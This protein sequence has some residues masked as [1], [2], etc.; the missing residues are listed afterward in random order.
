VKP[1]GSFEG[2][3]R[4]IGSILEH[5]G[6]TGFLGNADALYEQADDESAQWEAFLLSCAEA[7]GD[8]TVTS[9]DVALRL[10]SDSSLQDSLPDFL[11]EARAGG[12]GDFKKLLG[13]ALRKRA[14]RQYGDEGLRVTRAGT[15]TRKRVA[16]W[17]FTKTKR[18]GE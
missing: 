9:A 16:Q 1:L 7:F 14:D 18:K 12:K 17:K 8:A 6:I 11:A 2:W 3:T 10:A 13:N 5:A 4:I 15:D